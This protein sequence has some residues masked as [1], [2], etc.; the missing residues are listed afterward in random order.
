MRIQRGVKGE[1]DLAK[2]TTGMF[3]ERIYLAMKIIP[4]EAPR[5]KVVMYQ[6]IFDI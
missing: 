3:F 4:L 1:G 2:P 5:I 6:A